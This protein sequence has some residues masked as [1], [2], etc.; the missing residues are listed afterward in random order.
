MTL[1]S[2][3]LAAL[4]LAVLALPAAA[5][6]P[7]AVAV[8]TCKQ[9]S[10]DALKALKSEIKSALA[11][12]DADLDAVAPQF[13]G[14]TTPAEAIALLAAPVVAL[15]NSLAVGMDAAIN[16][17]DTATA[18]A[19][20][21]LSD[22]GDLL[23]VYP[24]VL[25]HGTRE[26]L[27]KHR[28]AVLKLLAKA[29]KSALKRLAATAAQAEHEN[30]GVTFTLELPALPSGAV[31]EDLQTLARLAQIDAAIGV[32]RLTS[33]DDGV[34]FVTGL[35]DSA[36]AIEVVIVGPEGADSDTADQGL[37]WTITLGEG[38]GLREGGYAVGAKQ[39]GAAIPITGT[40]LGLR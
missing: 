36:L 38:A 7:E 1:T 32:S 31:N 15:Q 24:D 4:A 22:G 13:S 20:D 12:L 37:R 6:A 28:E 35:T 34:I 25:Y 19:L 14:T 40:V 10:K 39:G 5:Q 2:F 23:G 16:D 33:S 8:A 17:F 18:S 21:Q 9:A 27:D 30:L 26:M 11:T 29:R 3:A